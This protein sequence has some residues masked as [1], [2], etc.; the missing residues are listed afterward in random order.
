MSLRKNRRRREAR[1][2]TSALNDILFI[3]LLF[4]LI[5]AT[6]ANPNVIKVTN[7]EASSE[8]RVKQTITV[9]IDSNQSFYLGTDPVTSDSLPSLINLSLADAS[10]AEED[11]TVVINADKLANAESIVL[12]ME[13]AK[14]VQAKTVFAVSNN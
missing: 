1:V 8:N 12:V 3:L 5:V 13:A 7:P 6:L 2:Y 11:R 14:A 4:F 9:T 10:N